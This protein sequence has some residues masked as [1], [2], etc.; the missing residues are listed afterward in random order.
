M[1]FSSL[2]QEMENKMSASVEAI[3]REFASLRTGRA[4]ASILDNIVVMAYGQ[5]TP[6]NQVASISVPDS[7]M[8]SLTV[9]DKG[10]VTAVEK[11]IRESNLGLNP[12]VDGTLIRIPMPALSE[13]RR[14][15]LTKVAGKYAETGKVA[16]RNV[17]RD[18]MEDVK[19]AA[20][21]KEITEDEQKRYEDEIQKSTDNF[22]REIDGVLAEKEKDIMQ[23]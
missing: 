6:I 1:D 17:R 14:L 11:A 9:W 16:I 4:Q 10:N 3:K 2:K 20:K 7:R 13:E 21:D 23:V 19:K 12:A 15:E 8:I 5:A 22:V 18:Y